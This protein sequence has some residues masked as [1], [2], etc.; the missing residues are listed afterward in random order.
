MILARRLH[1]TYGHAIPR[2]TV[3]VYRPV[4]HFRL[5]VER[6]DFDSG[7]SASAEFRS[8]G[9]GIEEAYT[10]YSERL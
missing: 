2:H 10:F 5:T 9:I 6:G 7:R 1:R 4:S 3:E 8:D